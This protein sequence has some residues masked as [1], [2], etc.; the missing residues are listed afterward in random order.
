[1]RISLMLTSWLLALLLYP[2]ALTLVLIADTLIGDAEFAHHL[3]MGSQ[4]ELLGQI[5]ADWLA[6]LLLAVPL[7]FFVRLLSRLGRTALVVSFC[8]GLGLTLALLAF[9]PP[10]LPLI[11]GAML[12]WTGGLNALFDARCRRVRA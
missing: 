3:L 6:A 8:L 1:M 2:L 12:I 10:Y 4:R 9:V 7:W 11:F 5:L